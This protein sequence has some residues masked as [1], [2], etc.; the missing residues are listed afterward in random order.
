MIIDNEA[1]ADLEIVNQLKSKHRLFYSAYDLRKKESINDWS[2]LNV[3]IFSIRYKNQKLD[4]NGF[5][6]NL[7]AI[8]AE[9]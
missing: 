9:R 3:N 4:E 7:I 6:N 2:G 1:D 5:K 8:R